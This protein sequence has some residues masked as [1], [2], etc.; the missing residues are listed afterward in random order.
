M[1]F[2]YPWAFLGMAALLGLLWFLRYQWTQRLGLDRAAFVVRVLALVALVITLAGPQSSSREAVRYVYFVVD[3]S[4]STSLSSDEDIVMQTLSQFEQSDERTRYGVIVY[5]KQAFID[6]PFS[7]NLPLNLQTTIDPSASDMAGALRLAL[8]TLPNGLQQGEGNSVDIVLLSDGQTD[9]QSLLGV[10]ERARDMGV[11]IWVRPLG[12]RTYA[13]VRLDSVQ[14]PR[15]VTPDRR[16]EGVAYVYT[17]EPTEG[18][19]LIYRDE[20]L[21]EA[22]PAQLDVGVNALRFAD[23]LTEPG[24]HRYQVRFKADNDALLENNVASDLVT[25]SGSAALLLYERPDGNGEGLSRLLDASGF[26]HERRVWSN[27][28]FN[29]SDLASYK[30]IILNN[31]PLEQLSTEAIDTLKAYT[32]ELGG[33]IWIIEGQQA[34]EGVDESELEEMLPVTFEGPQR[35]QLPGVAI[36]FILDRSSSMGQTAAAGSGLNKLDVLK[37]AAAQSIEVL[38]EEDWLGVSVFDSSHEATVPIQPLA[39]QQNRQRIYSLINQIS[40]GGGTDMLPP[41]LEALNELKRIPARIKHILVFSDGKTVRQDRNFQELFDELAGSDVTVSSIGLGQQ[42]DE[43]MLEMLA[44]AGQG[45]VFMVRDVTQLPKI[46]VRETRRIVQRRWVVGNFATEAGAFGQLRLSGFDINAMPP[47]S[48]YVQTYAKDLSQSA[49]TVEGNPLLSFW[50]YGLGQVAVL[51]TD[52]EGVWTD[53]WNGWSRL[54]EL[55]GEVMSQL[56]AN[57]ESNAGLVL[58]SEVDG[59]KLHLRLDASDGNRF[60]NQLEISGQL[61]ADE[62]E[63][64]ASAESVPIQF[65][66]VAP[67]QYE[68]TVENIQQGLSLVNLEALQEGEIA[69]QQTHVVS[70]PYPLEYQNL[71]INDQLLRQIADTTGGKVLEDEQIDLGPIGRAGQVRYEDL[72]PIGLGIAMFLF[73]GDLLLRKVPLE[74]LLGRGGE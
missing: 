1:R 25:V 13:D 64:D 74:A 56:Y 37:E 26:T 73:M 54:S 17:N 3:R 65:T 40:A 70:V 21:L 35:D 72:W 41:L 60:V 18:D 19:L 20:Q 63:G 32:S 11:R 62:A 5:G 34:L 30:G 66:Q 36:Y 7:S 44:E 6:Q 24:H 61:H 27:P 9:S 10:L 51:N 33:G 55:V 71:G 15:E 58:H 38:R 4:A 16:F 22:I 45:E 28:S 50:Q 8:E 48:G 69:T 57:P 67:G 47:V 53:Q 14:L 42:P 23:E 68:A 59:N 39:N 29:L 46:S 43:E 52:L 31:V 49:I 12:N 2:I